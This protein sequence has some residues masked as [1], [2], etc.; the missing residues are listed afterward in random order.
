MIL[1]LSVVLLATFDY[2]HA[3]HCSTGLASYMNTRCVGLNLKFVERSGCTFT[4]QGV[5]SAGQNQ[6]TILNLVD[7]LP[8]EPCKECCNGK[9]RPVQFGSLNPLTLKSCA[10]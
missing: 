3:N 8:C 2:L 4:C 5:N 9:C 10:K 6:I 1:T 7:G